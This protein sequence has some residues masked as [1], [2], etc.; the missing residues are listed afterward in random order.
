MK[1]NDTCISFSFNSKFGAVMLYFF[2]QRAGLQYRPGRMPNGT[3]LSH[4]R[5]LCQH[6]RQLH[7]SRFPVRQAF[8]DIDRD[9][10]RIK[11]NVGQGFSLAILTFLGRFRQL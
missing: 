5:A 4:D 11:G 1:F 3:P 8:I 6:G 10:Y 9:S 7:V 2:Y